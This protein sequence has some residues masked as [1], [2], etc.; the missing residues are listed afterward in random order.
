[1]NAK[2]REEKIRLHTERDGGCKKGCEEVRE[3]TDDAPEKAE[4]LILFKLNQG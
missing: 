4:S 1:M 3:E 2:C